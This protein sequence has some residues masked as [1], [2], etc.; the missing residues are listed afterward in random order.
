MLDFPRWKISL[1]LG[2]CALALYWCL[3]SFVPALQESEHAWVPSKT[4]S[5]G[6]DLQG[7][8]HLLLEVDTEHYLKE[9]LESAKDAARAALRKEKLGYRNLRVSDDAVTLSLR[10][11]DEEEAVTKVLKTL[12]ARMSVTQ[13]GQ[14]FRLAF[15]EQAEREATLQLLEQSMEIVRRRVDE[16]GTREPIIQRQGTRRIV[17]Q[18]P[19][20]QDPSRLKEL[21]GKTANLTF[22]MVD[23]GID[24]ISPLVP[25]PEGSEILPY[26]DTQSGAT[27]A[28]IGIKK[29]VMLAGDALV[30][31]HATFQEGQPV[32]SFRFNTQGA[33][34]FGDITTQSVNRR[35]AIILD[36][37]VI[38]APVI[39][40][41][42]RGGS[43]IIS[44]NFTVE[45]ANDLALLLRAGA[46]PAPL[47]ILEE[48][49]VGPSL[50]ADSIAAGSKA[51]LLGVVLVV[52]FM[53]ASYGL[54]GV[55]SNIALMMNMALIFSGLSLFQATLT[56][57]GIAGIVLTMG[58]AVD[59][60]VLIF[61]RIKEELRNG[62]T[63][64]AAVD[65]GFGRAFS[66]ILD[67]N[68]TTL[69]AAFLLYYFGSGAIK[70]FAVTLSIGILSSM[71]SAI[72]LTRM[73][74]ALYVLRKKPRTLSI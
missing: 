35:F 69:I 54:F 10:A 12:D 20:L 40:E 52:V 60:N 46:L 9:Q 58:M 64:I 62:K 15:S 33:K 70:G 16:T 55:F 57:P 32:V 39:R 50:G 28:Y 19:G 29:R 6:L 8:S 41:P 42:I 66:T 2:F 11:A 30:D 51:A 4:L 45:S 14:R 27:P 13:E 48:R 61:E 56:L 49:T 74:V 43:G 65:A 71:F 53:I 24:A 63:V 44:G 72:L 23:E 36:N 1:I 25:A 22:R 73:M 17:L 59:A 68:F 38:S 5:L 67:S 7:G 37:A 34:K 31:A 18:V 26:Q 21:L 3:P 47:A